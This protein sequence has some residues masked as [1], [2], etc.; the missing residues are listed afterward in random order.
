MYM[1]CLFSFAYLLCLTL[2]VLAERPF[3]LVVHRGPDTLRCTYLA[4][5]ETQQF[6]AL[7]EGGYTKT[8]LLHTGEERIQYISHEEERVWDRAEA[9]C[10]GRDG[11]DFPTLL[12]TIAPPTLSAEQ[13]VFGIAHSETI[14]LEVEP[15]ITSGDSSNRV[16]LVFF[17]DGYTSEEKAKFIE[18]ARRLAEDISGNQTF[19]TVKPLLNF[20][21]A[22]TP[23]KESGIGTG[24]NTKDTPFGLYRDGTELRSVWYSKPEVARKACFSLG[25]QCDYPILMGN[26]PLY[27]GLGGEFT[28][29]TPSLANGA[30]VLRHELGHS[31]ID[32]GEEYDGAESIDYFGVN[33][34][35]DTSL[36]AVPWAHWLTKAAN[37]PHSHLH[38]ETAAAPRVE[39]AAMPL[40]EYAWT[41]LNTSVSW[42]TKFNSS[43]TYTWHLVRFSLSG[44][45]HAEDLRVALDGKDLGWVPRQDIGVDRWHY[46]IRIDSPLSPG[47]HEVTFTLRSKEAEGE[48]QLCSIEIL[49]FGDDDE[50]VSNPGHY[51]LYPTFSEKNATT[52]RPTNEDCLM[53]LVTTPNF[54]KVCTEGLWHA[55][56]RRVT[57]ID[58]LTVGCAPSG[59]SGERTLDLALVPLAHLRARPVDVEESYEVTWVRDGVEVREWKNQTSVVDAGDALGSYAVQVRY[60]TEEVRVDPDRLLESEVEYVVTT[61]CA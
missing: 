11:W 13:I 20:W 61:R 47:E 57:L 22:F 28:V 58:T 43:G 8:R 16:D 31:I 12:H 18:D 15:L 32:V 19:Y 46:D 36:D 37:S 33:T 38:N 10:G 2:T 41:L 39:R 4:L 1:R 29:I 25:D 6:R 30:L 60:W 3:E 56:L 52:Y 50:F 17:A 27:G 9:L 55:L 40:Q 59:P 5:R 51:S 7:P 53:R 35:Q 44:I 26:D 54:C 49:E 23:S 34:A 14:P 21:A 24:G 42:S 48:A 45:P